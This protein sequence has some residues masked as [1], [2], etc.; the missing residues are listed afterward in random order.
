MFKMIPELNNASVRMR[1]QGRVE[2]IISNM[3]RAG[4]STLQV[5]SDFDMTLTRFAHKGKRC[6]TTH[7]ILHN[8]TLISEECKAKMSDLVSYY[9][10]IEIDSS[11]SVE[12][13]IPH[14][15]EWW[16]Q[17]HTLLI[18]QRIRKDQ[19][20]QA[21]RDSGAMLREGYRSFFDVLKENAVPLLIFSAG[22]GDILE[23]VIIGHGVF[24][25]NVRV[26]SNYM[27]YDKDGFACAFKGELIHTF[28]KREG[29]L[30]NIHQF[31]HDRT[32]VLLL[33]DSLGDLDMAD[34]VQDLE[35][36]LRIGYLNDKVEER[37]EAYVSSYDIVLEEDETLD[38]PN[39]ILYY[40]TA[41]EGS[42]KHETR[43]E[44][45]HCQKRNLPEDTPV[46]TSYCQ[47]HY[48]PGET[49]V[50]MPHCQKRQKCSSAKGTPASQ[51]LAKQE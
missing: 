28:N 51:P 47:K 23:E 26:F 32:N 15:Q 8:T 41:G 40:I 11:K 1:D 29:A 20:A 46:E 38:V 49:C 3:Q 22:V 5:I 14:M 33:G 2:T 27:D 36:I 16:T 24:S 43:V 50:G 7:N 35:N 4:A 44:T 39:A 30:Q 37:R 6:P 10:P 19:L 42:Q 13:K 12:E 31:V 9:Y 34:G 25:S 21:V 18:K 17:A 48:L 45:P